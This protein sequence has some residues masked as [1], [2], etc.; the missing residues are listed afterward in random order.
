MDSSSNETVRRRRTWGGLPLRAWIVVALIVA[1]VG[2]W[3]MIDHYLT[4]QRARIADAKAWA[5]AGPA[6]PRITEAEFLEGSRKPIRK[7]DYEE[8]TFLR[9]E[10]HVDC[11]PI[12]DEGGR[13][14]RFHAV[15]QFTDPESLLVQTNKGAWAFRPGPRQP[16]T[17]S[18]AGGEA[19][20]VMA[21]KITRAE[22]EA[23]R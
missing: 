19:R 4:V 15:C 7:F 20:C 8:T 5:I 1:A 9:R 6:C 18:A 3:R 21:A 2:A 17:V 14:T 22:M 13:S 16:V 11:A 10:G 23:G 12:Y